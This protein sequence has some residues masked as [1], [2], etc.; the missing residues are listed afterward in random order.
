M[1]DRFHSPVSQVNQHEWEWVP[2][3]DDQFGGGHQGMRL[4]GSAFGQET[5]FNALQIR[6]TN[7]HDSEAPGTDTVNPT[8]TAFDQVYAVYKTALVQSTL[9][10]SVSLQPVYSPDNGT[11]WLAF[12]TA[13]TVNAYGG[14]G[15]AQSAII[16]LSSPSQ[17]LP[18]VGLQATCAAA[19]A[20][21]D[22]NGQLARLG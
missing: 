15:P 10:Q 18:L 6:D 20:S 3:S 11:T 13:T 7:P 5:L 21:G 16:V 12:G 14:T 4:V 17:Y 8:G 22:L 2:R 1:G 19:P 9:D